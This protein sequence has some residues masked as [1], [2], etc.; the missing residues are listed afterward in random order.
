MPG[1]AIRFCVY[2]MGR[3]DGPSVI[4]NTD[5]EISRGDF[6]NGKRDGR[7]VTVTENGR[8]MTHI[9]DKGSFKYRI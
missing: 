7:W 3:E 1:I 9:W 4:V 8:K 2:Y 5:G 6:A